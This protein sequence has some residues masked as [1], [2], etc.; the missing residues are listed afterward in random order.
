MSLS[1]L[2]PCSSVAKNLDCWSWLPI[3]IFSPI[4][5]PFCP[6]ISINLIEDGARPP[7]RLEGNMKFPKV[8]FR[9]EEA[10]FQALL[11]LVH[12]EGPH[13][14]KCGE[15]DQIHRHQNSRQP[16]RVHYL[17]SHCDHIFKAWTGTLL[18]GTHRPPSQILQI[19][20]GMLDGEPTCPCASRLRCD[21]GKLG[22]FEAH[23]RLLVVQLFG[24]LPKK[25]RKKTGQ[26]S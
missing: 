11:A 16:W 1:V 20:K 26:K 10:C 14:P 9:N 23:T 24:P 18:Q 8:N 25:R 17:C 22:K 5:V 6:R 12:P 13:C 15:R 4:R 3:R 7:R 19:W 21:R 2:G